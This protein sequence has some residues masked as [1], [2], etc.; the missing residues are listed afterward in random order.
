MPQQ[1]PEWA[2]PKVNSHNNGN[3]NN[4]CNGKSKCYIDGEC[5]S[6]GQSDVCDPPGQRVPIDGGY[7]EVGM[8]F[9]ALVLGLILLTKDST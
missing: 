5:V 4:E 6:P 9:I 7:I 3:N 2:E 1:L 8:I